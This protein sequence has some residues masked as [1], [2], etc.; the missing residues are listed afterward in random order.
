MHNERKDRTGGGMLIHFLH[1]YKVIGMLGEK[2]RIRGV[3]P[4]IK[5]EEFIFLNKE[6][7]PVG[8][9]YRIEHIEY[10]ESEKNVFKA[11][12]AVE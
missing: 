3:F 2:M 4:G 11:V 1:E 9:T 8:N 12:I 6:D 7:L 5:K 10:S